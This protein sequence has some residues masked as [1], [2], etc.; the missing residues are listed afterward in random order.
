MTEICSVDKVLQYNLLFIQSK[1]KLAQEAR[2]LNRK[3][4]TNND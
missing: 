3:I 4:R 1:Y 2:N